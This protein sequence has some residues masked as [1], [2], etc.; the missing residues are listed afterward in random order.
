VVYLDTDHTAQEGQAG[1][2]SY[3]IEEEAGSTVHAL[4]GGELLPPCRERA[5]GNGTANAGE[6]S[7][8]RWATETEKFYPRHASDVVKLVGKSR[9]DQGRDWVA[10]EEASG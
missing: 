1:P 8:R 9:R 2:S 6:G 10:V 3:E 4:V 5:C 7:N